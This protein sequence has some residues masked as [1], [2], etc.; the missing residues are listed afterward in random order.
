MDRR[1]FKSMALPFMAVPLLMAHQ[2]AFA[3]SIGDLTNAQ[4]S[5]GLKTALERGALAATPR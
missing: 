2:R 4:A 5:Q 1:A 3:L